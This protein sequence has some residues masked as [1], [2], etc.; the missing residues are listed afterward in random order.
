[1]NEHDFEKTAKA[2]NP[3]GGSYLP[4][5]DRL[6]TDTALLRRIAYNTNVIRLVL[7]WTMVV[8]PIVLLA[9]AIPVIVLSAHTT[10]STTATC[11]GLYGNC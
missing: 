5:I 6:T 9:I 8:V 2:N 3:G 10:G 4:H 1:M 7:I 11:V